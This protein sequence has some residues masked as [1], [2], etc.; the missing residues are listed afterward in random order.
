MKKIAF[1][2]LVAVVQLHAAEFGQVATSGAQLLKINFDP[3][4]SALGYAA[5]SVVGNAAAV[6]TNI[7][8]TAAVQNAD[9]AFTYMPYFAGIKMMA[10]AG[11]Y[12]MQDVG[13][14]SV[15]AAGFSTDEEVTTIEQ[16]NGTG[17]RYSISN[18]V[19]GVVKF[20]FA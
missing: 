9:V 18:V 19:V 14:F 1:L 20:E 11:A 10:A 6:Y 3:R 5:A 7:A 17:E 13:V 16:E 15:H 8:G 4:A 12:H 2:L